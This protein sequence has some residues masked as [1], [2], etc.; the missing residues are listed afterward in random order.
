MHGGEI[1]AQGT[2][3]EIMEN[4]RSLTGRYLSGKSSIPVPKERR[5]NTG[6]VYFIKGCDLQ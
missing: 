3:L 6:P 2:P 4:P 5:L 1:V